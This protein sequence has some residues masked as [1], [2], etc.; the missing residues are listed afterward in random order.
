MQRQ[1]A[2]RGWLVRS[3]FS[4]ESRAIV[5]MYFEMSGSELDGIAERFSMCSSASRS[6]AV[7]TEFICQLHMQDN[8][9]ALRVVLESQRPH[10]WFHVMLSVRGCIRH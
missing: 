6:R 3:S 10:M 2:G 7:I 5:E 1:H 9:N 4:A 8:V